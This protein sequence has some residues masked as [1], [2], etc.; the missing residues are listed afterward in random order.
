MGVMFRIA[1]TLA[2]AALLAAPSAIAQ[3]ARAPSVLTQAIAATTAARM[4]YAFDVQLTSSRTNWRARFEPNGDPRVRL[5]SPARENLSGGERRAFDNYAEGMEGVPWCA[6]AYMGR[7]ADVRLV[8]EDSATATYAFQPT[9]ESIRNAESR[10]FA[11][12]M[13]GEMTLTKENA[14]ITRIRIYAPQ[15][16]DAAPLVRLDHMDIVV[17]CAIAPNGRRYAAES[18]TEMRGSA[19][20]QAFDERSVQRASNLSA[21]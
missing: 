17:R 15:G 3:G 21:P 5:V 1:F 9:R 18:V 4:A 2:L 12:R 14:D 20:G 13:R 16:F 10:R 7:I 11:E 8:S 19:F 6:D